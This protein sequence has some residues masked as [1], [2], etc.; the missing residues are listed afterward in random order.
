MLVKHS[1]WHFCSHPCHFAGNLA[2]LEFWMFYSPCNYECLKPALFLSLC[3]KAIY[4]CLFFDKCTYCKALLIKA[5]ARC[6]KCKCKKAS[7]T[8]RG[9][10]QCEAN[11]PVAILTWIS[12]HQNLQ[13][14]FLLLAAGPRRSIQGNLIL[15]APK[16]RTQY[17]PAASTSGQSMGRRSN[18]EGGGSKGYIRST[19]RGLMHSI[20]DPPA[21]IPWADLP[22]EPLPESVTGWF[23][24]EV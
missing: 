18:D 17:T 22:G 19:Q 5:S 10:Y 3:T 21:S 24:S 23:Y 14:C 15:A 2:I 1:E 8:S 12:R 6:P 7:H 13:N 16:Q 4:C 20:T 9:L 11:V